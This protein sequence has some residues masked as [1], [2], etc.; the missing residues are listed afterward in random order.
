MNTK[1]E[2]KQF[3]ILLDDLIP[4]QTMKASDINLFQRSFLT[5]I[6]VIIV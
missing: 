5:V 4:K 1:A 2:H 6:S 3:V